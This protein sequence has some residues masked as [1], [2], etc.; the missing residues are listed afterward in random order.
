MKQWY[1]KLQ[2][3]TAQAMMKQAPWLLLRPELG[4]GAS[5]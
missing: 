5:E 3:M 1:E 4:T 2:R